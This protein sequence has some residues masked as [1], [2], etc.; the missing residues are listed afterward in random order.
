MKSPQV[1]SVITGKDLRA[2][3]EAEPLTDLFELRIDLIGDGWLD[4]VSSLKKPWI[5]TNRLAD[6]GGSWQESEARRK[7]E[8]LKAISMGATIIDIEFATKNLSETV[9]LVKKRASCLVSHHDLKETPPLSCLKKMVSKQ[10]EAGAD[11]CKV[12]TTAQKLEDNLTIL[13][14]IGEF[15][16]RKVVAF[17][18]GPLGLASRL[19]CPLAGSPFVYAAIKKG[20]EST[21]GQLM[22]NELTDFYN[23]IKQ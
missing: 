8:L 20:E 7:E 17:A 22:V 16:Q 5:A 1:C 12:V 18:M 2:I 14:L 6:Q 4:V 23:L 13:K 15:P 19:L 21:A 10:L 3:V 11:I 9:A